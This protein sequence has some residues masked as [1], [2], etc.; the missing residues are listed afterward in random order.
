MYKFDR[1]AKL[2]SEILRDGCIIPRGASDKPQV[3]GIQSDC[4]YLSP[5]F[6]TDP[7]RMEVA[8]ENVYIL[9]HET[10][11]SSKKGLLSLLEG[12]TKSCKPLVIIAE[13][14]GDE[15]LELSS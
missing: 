7:E 15:A 9:L 2:K 5:Y 11:M 10:K 6:V 14:V 1:N 12:I 4:G 13:D 3:G 8:F